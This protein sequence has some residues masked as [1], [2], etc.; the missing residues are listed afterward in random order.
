MFEEYNDEHV[1]TGS[2]YQIVTP[3]CI[4]R[5]TY[6]TVLIPA[7]LQILGVKIVDQLGNTWDWEYGSP[8]ASLTSWQIEYNAVQKEIG[9]V[10][11]WYD[12]YTY[13][14]PIGGE[15]SFRFFT[16]LLKEESN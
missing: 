7:G 5:N 6:P 3:P 12:K 16:F 15:C 1:L 13:N 10:Q 14:M 11:V 2:G 9:G 4:E 8:E